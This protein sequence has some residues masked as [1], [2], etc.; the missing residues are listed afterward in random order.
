M[1]TYNL[2]LLDFPGNHEKGT[3]P[4]G[5]R[6]YV[7]LKA[8]SQIKWTNKDGKKETYFPAITPECVSVN[9][10][11]YEINRLIKE[12]QTIE[13]QSDKFFKKEKTQ[14]KA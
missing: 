9:E 13:K 4:F 2:Q 6:A 5:P 10:F 11:K 12:L 7:V 3:L 1:T 14:S 8:S